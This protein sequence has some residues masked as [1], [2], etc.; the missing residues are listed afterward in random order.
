M[1]Q[2]ITIINVLK[3][4]RIYHTLFFLTKG[5]DNAAVAIITR[6]VGVQKSIISTSWGLVLSASSAFVLLEASYNIS[7]SSSSPI[8]PFVNDASPITSNMRST[9]G[10]ARSSTVGCNKHNTKVTY[11][12][13]HLSI[14]SNSIF[15]PKLTQRLCRN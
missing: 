1:Q 8:D 15:Q 12:N 7:S 9:Y 5:G 2:M 14:Q 3:L 6:M 4:L 10:N 11:H 13:K